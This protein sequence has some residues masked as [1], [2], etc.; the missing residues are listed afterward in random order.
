LLRGAD[1]GMLVR[2]DLPARAE[3]LMEGAEERYA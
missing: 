3:A 2:I 1:G